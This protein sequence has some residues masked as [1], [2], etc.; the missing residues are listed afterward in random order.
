MYF[1]STEDFFKKAEES[2]RL[3]REE[4]KAL[5]LLKSQGDTAARD[6]LVQGYLAFAASFVRRAPENIRTLN[7]VYACVDCLEKCV[8]RFDFTK[9]G[10]PFVN[11]LGNALRRCI[12]RCIAFRS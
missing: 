5:G 2:H 12:T 7:T 9:D 8:D 11:H 10:E 4:E 6:V 1:T 3:S